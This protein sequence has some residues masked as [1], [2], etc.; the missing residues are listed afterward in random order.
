MNEPD[1]NELRTRTIAPPSLPSMTPTGSG[2]IGDPPLGEARAASTRIGEYV[3]LGELGRGGMGV[4]YRAEDPRLKR[5]V[6]LKVML[7]QFAANP[8]AKARF[9]REARAQAKVEHDHVAAIFTVADHDGL[10]YIVMPLLKGMTLQ[11]AIKANPR[12]PLNEVIRIG[13]EVAEGLAAAHEKGLVHRDIKPANIW[14][15]GKKLRVKVLD[16]G[17]ARTTVEVEA[18]EGSEGPVTNEGAIV[19]TPAY[20]SPEQG[21]GLPVDGRTDL[22]SLGVM[23]YQMTVGELPFRGPTSLA[24][25]TSL[26]FDNPP[27]PITRNPAVPQS[28]SDFVMRLLAKDPAY[29]PPT[30][31][32]AADELRAI[33]AGLVNAVRVIALD[34]PPPIILQPTGPDPFA[35]LD[36]TEANSAPDAE[37][38][39]DEEQTPLR[40]A[41]SGGGIPMWAIVAGVLLA[42]AG[43]VGFVA[44][45]MGKKP[46]SEVAK[47]EP[48]PAPRP[49]TTTKPK[50]TADPVKKAV[51]WVLANGGDVAS[52]TEGSYQVVTNP[53]AIGGPIGAVNISV[54]TVDDTALENLRA[55]PA[56]TSLVLRL[57][58]I[59]DAGAKCLAG[60]PFAKTLTNL[61]LSAANLTDAGLESL[62]AFTNLEFL[63]VTG[64]FTPAGLMKLQKLPKLNR[65]AFGD[66][67]LTDEHL[68][69]LKDLPLTSIYLGHNAKLTGAGLPNLGRMASLAG[70]VYPGNAV[71][72]ED[73]KTIVSA[74]P[75]LSTLSL[76]TSG[77]LCPV[78]N[79]GLA[80]LRG[81]RV[82]LLD[83][84]ASAL[85][86]KTVTPLPRCEIRVNGTTIAEASDAHFREASRLLGRGCYVDVRPVGGAVTRVKAPADLPDGP[87]ELTGIA[88]VSNAFPFTD[89]DLK[90]LEAT[91]TLV[92]LEL[93]GVTITVTGV[94][95]ALAS[96]QTLILLYL[97]GA[98]SLTDESLRA[99][100]ECPNLESFHLGG[101]K[102]T[103]AGLKHVASLT[104]LH[105]VGV[106]GTAV[107]DA[108]L[109][110][111]AGLPALRSLYLDD[112]AVSDGGVE[113]LREMKGLV[114]LTLMGTR[115]SAAGHKRLAD[116]LPNC[117]IVWEDPNRWVAKYLLGTPGFG[118]T[119]RTAAGK[120]IDVLRAEDLPA[121]TFTLTRVNRGKGITALTDNHLKWLEATPTLVGIDAP[122]AQ[123][124][125]GGLRS[126]LAH[127]KTLTSLYFNNVKVTD[128]GCAVLAELTELSDLNVEGE[129]GL[130]TDAGV[131]HLARAPK[132]WSLWLG[133][134]PVTDACLKSLAGMKQLRGLSL[135]DTVVSDAGIETL[136]RMTHLEQLGLERTRVTEAG[137]KKLQAALPKCKI[138]WEDPNR[139]VATMLLTRPDQAALK[140]TLELPDGKLV[141]VEKVDDLPKGPFTLVGLYRHGGF[142][143]LTESELRALESIPT[144]KGIYFPH[145]VISPTGIRSLLP[146]KKALNSLYLVQSNLT[147]EHLKVIGQLTALTS[148][149]L[150]A[151]VSGITDAGLGHLAGLTKLESLFLEELAITDAGLRHLTS[152]P[153]LT[154]LG[155]SK[156]AI[157]DAGIESLAKLKSLVYLGIA[158]TRITEAGFKRL[159]K[160]LPMCQI[161]WEDPNRTVAKLFLERAPFVNGVGGFQFDLKLPDGK[162][163]NV[164]KAADLPAGPFAIVRLTRAGPQ[165]PALTDADI[166]R[167]EAVPTLTGFAA[168]GLAIGVDGLRSL[169]ASNKSLAYLAI[170]AVTD[171]HLKV[172][173]GFPELTSLQ[174]GGPGLTVTDT[175]IAHLAGLTKLLALTM[176]DTSMTDAGFKKHFGGLPSLNLLSLTNSLVSDDSVP[177]IA[178]MKTLTSLYLRDTRITEAGY[179]KLKDA[180]PNCKIEWSPSDADRKAAEALHPHTCV[181]LTLP[182]GTPA[183]VMPNQ[184]LPAGPF[185]LVAIS[186]HG[187][188]RTPGF[189]GAAV[190]R[191]ISQLRGFTQIGAC[192]PLL[193]T[194][195]IPLQFTEADIAALADSPARETLGVIS[196]GVPLTPKS[197]A[198]LT[199]FP[200]LSSLGVTA[201]EAD[202][203]VLA[204]LPKL[205]GIVGLSTLGLGKSGKVTAKGWANFASLPLTRLD[206][207]APVGLDAAAAK[208]LVAIPTLEFLTVNETTLDEAAMRELGRSPKLTTLWIE[209]CTL[210]SNA[211][212]QIAA[213]KSLTG[214]V[215]ADCPTLVDAD[216]EPLA[217]L[218]NLREL[219]LGPTTVTDAAVKKLAERLPQCKI[220]W[221]VGKVIEPVKKP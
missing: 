48:P 136:A 78:T 64:K 109:K 204:E 138:R 16:F 112:T 50:D 13:R 159:Q 203:A 126:L 132:L 208:Q 101:T 166:K 191:A 85:T 173:G 168:H 14:L 27:P 88:R 11:A 52:G 160:E 53:D 193:G 92:T 75:G 103:D 210:P 82:R 137:L 102:V 119:V 170:G 38:V 117:K 113:T 149:N 143:A 188:P 167:L 121:E 105:T 169:L 15:E 4:V 44:S 97:A 5:E 42:V 148:V 41:K 68:T 128:A 129:A 23:L 1:P 47:E 84:G 29:R 80:H 190:V 69:A 32:I 115:I 17:L 12:P 40:A 171:E 179:K 90:R 30:A 6:A 65:I 122:G 62:T 81:S 178:N 139:W 19:G 181:F 94:R 212:K 152:L 189:D 157:S 51:A 153:A 114:E 192:G 195:P 63:G 202:D 37:P 95:S 197:I 111:L 67:G 36:A 196:G 74:M 25:L 207:I 108:G 91:P 145:L 99:M 110:H 39:E 186:M 21:R 155:L 158:G 55:L 151:T 57:A 107:T 130:I 163:V 31:E 49:V 86:A 66:C 93:N 123:I 200:K 100:G 61:D 89:E 106:T 217:T 146:S 46:E 165:P 43:V 150:S 71:K 135:A 221:G 24:I 214:L 184:P 2:T 161:V 35:D 175:G 140:V 147:D 10:P 116:A 70:L 133:G 20:M 9:V 124:T 172:I 59:T 73:I 218:T 34:A 162:I 79:E 206:L 199:R 96:M 33:E 125:E 18:T 104:R 174:F 131:A 183:S 220:T 58:P 211:G 182:S 83:L 194:L 176:V 154:S 216:L 215:L 26:A 219:G 3:L 144:L 60:M 98:A 180:M 45:Q 156:T 187:V 118:V 164:G 120:D 205:R 8:T 141:S 28:L 56:L 76:T 198:L 54:A 22:W 77:P 127:R 201:S 213:M 72:D 142:H 185:T 177:T 87:F 134:S 7:P 209:K